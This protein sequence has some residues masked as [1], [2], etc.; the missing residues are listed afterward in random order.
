MGDVIKINYPATR[1]YIALARREKRTSPLDCTDVELDNMLRDLRDDTFTKALEEDEQRFKEINKQET[2]RING[3]IVSLWRYRSI[4]E[5]IHWFHEQ[6]KIEGSSF[7]VRL[8]ENFC[9]KTLESHNIEELLRDVNS[10]RNPEYLSRVERVVKD[11]L[12][13]ETA[14]NRKF[15][16]PVGE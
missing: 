8:P 3:D 13:V 7:S 10:N 15:L 6:Q 1:K 5:F 16:R 9:Y 4:R 11:F 14:R 12:I 2:R